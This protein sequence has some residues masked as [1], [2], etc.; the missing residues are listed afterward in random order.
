METGSYRMTRPAIGNGTADLLVIGGGSGGLSAARAAAQRGADVVLIERG[1]LGGEC[2][3][4]ACMPSKALIAAAHQGCSFDEAMKAVRH[5]VESVA[6][7]VDDEALHR[8]EVRVV[9]GPARFT[10]PGVVDVDGNTWRC[11]RIVLA[12][13]SRPVVP[14]VAGL[15]QVRLLTNENVFDLEHRPARLGVLGGGAMGCELAQA[16]QR[17]GT[18]VTLIEAEARLLPSEEAET[19][20]VIEHVLR[21]DNIDVRVNTRLTRVEATAPGQATL[22]LSD[23]ADVDVDALLVAIGRVAAVDGLGLDN[24]G[25]AVADGT[26][27]TNDRLATSARGVWAV[28]DVNGKL[29]LTHAADEMGRIAVANALGRWR[30]HRFDPDAIPA[31]VFTD[32]EVAR[33]GPTLD[34]LKGRRYRVAYLPMTEVDRAIAAGETDGFVQLVARPR[35]LLR[36]VGGGRLVGATVVASRAG[37]LISETAL[38]VRTGMF[39]GRLAQTVH[40]YPSWSVALRQAAAQFFMEIDG[41]RA[42]R[43]DR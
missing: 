30:R 28:G 7:T 38:A 16:F 6:A 2:T 12:T 22:L 39:V 1:R 40:P 9:H 32:P 42:R 43:R 3:Y 14:S 19:S 10:A 15:E 26:I 20:A 4:T 34:N 23:G 13:G 27:V 31:V 5:V 37:E 41:R 33:V 36:D 35:R 18:T 11:R 8:D 24:A 17:L 25:I 29:L 21:R